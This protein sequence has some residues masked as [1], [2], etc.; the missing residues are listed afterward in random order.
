MAWL[1]P[2]LPFNELAHLPPKETIETPEILK[3]AIQANRYL[4][5]LKGYCQTLPNPKLLLNTVILQESKDSS[6]IENIVTTQDDLY[7]AILNPL[8]QVP[9][10]TKEV[11]SYREAMYIGVDELKKRDVFT[12]NL[13]IKIMQRIKNTTAEY[14]NAPGVK[15]A[16]P[17]TKKV[18]YTPPDPQH[19]PNKISKWEKFIN[20]EDEYDPLIVMALMHYQFEAIHPFAD[21]N[22][23]TGRILNVLYLVHKGLLT[24]PLLYHSAYIIQHKEEYYKKLRFVTEK[25]DWI[26]WVG[27]MLD[28]VKTTALDTLITIKAIIELKEA[29]LIRIKGISQKLPAYELNELIFSFPYVKIKTLIDKGIAKRQTA[30]DYLQ[31]LETKGVLK[32]IKYGREIYYI[33]FRLMDLL[34]GRLKEIEK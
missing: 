20:E 9:S 24:H 23:R 32:S 31:E 17:I 27:F 14:R 22:G 29:N 5:E 16:N 11:I 3:K 25:D 13:A 1:N 4:A 19:V 12:G 18:I 15:L 28:A 30:S 34:T 8:E 21:G 2:E 33:N 10:N 26:G 7:R 6:A